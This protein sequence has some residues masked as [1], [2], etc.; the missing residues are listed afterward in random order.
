[1]ILIDA[2]TRCLHIFLLSN[3]NVEFARF[4]AQIIRLR[5]QFLDFLIKRLIIDNTCEFISKSFNDYCMFIRVYVGHCVAH[6]ITQNDLTESLIAR[7]LI[8]RSNLP[9]SCWGHAILNVAS[10]ICI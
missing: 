8:L 1:M 7:P 3:R 5:A 9:F 4:L 2:S 10:L 6:T